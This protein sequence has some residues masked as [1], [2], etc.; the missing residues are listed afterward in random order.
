MPQ[1]YLVQLTK[2]NLLVALHPVLNEDL[3][4]E[5]SINCPLILEEDIALLLGDKARWFWS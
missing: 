3:A 4:S 1:C 5:Q 2:E